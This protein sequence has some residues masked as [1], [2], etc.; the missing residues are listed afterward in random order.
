MFLLFILSLSIIIY[1]ICLELD[2]P[3]TPCTV[4]SGVCPDCAERVESGWLVCPHC[5]V[6]L[7]EACP[8]CGK[9]HDRWVTYCPW[10]RHPRQKANM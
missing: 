4:L 3:E 7:R 9:A 2:K 10:C 1:F 5:R 8:D 6:V